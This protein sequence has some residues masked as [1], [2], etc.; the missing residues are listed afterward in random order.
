[1]LALLNYS[2]P[3]T[4]KEIAD[5]CSVSSMR[6]TLKRY[7]QQGLLKR[8][9]ENKK[10]NTPYKYEIT[11]K[12]IERLEYLIGNTSIKSQIQLL[13]REKIKI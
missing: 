1:M 10:Q 6:T 3:Y 7:C 2:I 9:R 12:G 11:Q 13:V 4:A 8:K 5:L